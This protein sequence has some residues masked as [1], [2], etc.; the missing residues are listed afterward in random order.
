[1]P[2]GVSDIE[3]LPFLFIYLFIYLFICFFSFFVHKMHS[4]TFSAYEVVV[5]DTC[6]DFIKQNPIFEIV[7]LIVC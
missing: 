5:F 3:Y 6:Q 1:M 7:M 2:E 4:D